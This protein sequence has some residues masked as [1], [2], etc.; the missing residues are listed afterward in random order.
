M[1]QFLKTLHKIEENKDTE[2]ARLEM[3]LGFNGSN[4]E[5]FS[6]SQLV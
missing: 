4:K 3:V 6:V 5:K 2:T 1:K